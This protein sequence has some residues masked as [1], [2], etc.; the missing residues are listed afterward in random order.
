MKPYYKHDCD[1]CV[2]LG[3]DEEN[4]EDLYY[5]PEQIGGGT[6]IARRSS[7]GPE[8]TSYLAEFFERKE[9]IASI[10]TYRPS[11]IKAYKLAQ[12]QKLVPAI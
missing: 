12:K 9:F 7:D 10:K 8:Y 6:I 5:C 2:F 4:K 11:L 3:I 1:Q